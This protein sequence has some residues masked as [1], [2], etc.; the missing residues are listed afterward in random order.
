VAE[1]LLNDCAV[2]KQ[3]TLVLNP[4]IEVSERALAEGW[5]S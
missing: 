1:K 4:L 3:E 5:H 2:L